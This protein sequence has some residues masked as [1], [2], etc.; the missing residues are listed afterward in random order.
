MVCD[1]TGSEKSNMAGSKPE[2]HIS[3]LVDKI[4]TTFQRLCLYFR[5]P[6][7]QWEYPEC[8]AT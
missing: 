4:G 5:G 2:V 1:L 8:C 3:Q 6:A 7:S